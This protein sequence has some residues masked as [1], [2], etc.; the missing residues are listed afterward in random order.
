[1]NKVQKA[2]L[3]KLAD[4]IRTVPKKHFDL[5]YYIIGYPQDIFELKKTN[6]KKECGT[7]ACA[8]GWMPT[9]FK[10]FSGMDFGWPEETEIEAFFGINT[11]EYSYLFIPDKY[12]YGRRG[13]VSVANRIENFLE[14]GMPNFYIDKTY[15]WTR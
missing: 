6:F 3:Q 2:R 14:K 10:K 13:K 15:S 9:I 12:P 11:D 8:V 4:F 1:M 7:T 5:N